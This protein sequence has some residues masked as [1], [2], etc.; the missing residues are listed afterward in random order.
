LTANLL[1]VERPPVH[2]RH[3]EEI[4]MRASMRALSWLA[5][6][7]LLA[8][9]PAVAQ[10]VPK[11]T[12]DPAWPKPLPN[13][14]LLGQVAHVAVDS[15]DHVWLLQRPKSLTDD[16]K[17]ATLK[18]PRNQCCAPAPS[19]M[20]LDADGNFIQGWGFPDTKPWVANEH[21]IWVDRSGSVWIAGNA[22]DDSAIYKF[23]RDGKH[24]L[25]IGVAG[26]TGGSNDT[27]KLGRPATLTV[28]EDA[29]ELIVADG[30]GNRRVIVFDSQ[31]GAFKR[32]WGAYGN[33]PNDDK[34][35]PYSPD[36]PV[37][38]QFA[39]PVHCATPSRDGHLYVCDRTNNRIQVFRKDGT[40]VTEWF[41][42]KATLG[43][44]STWGLAT[45][46]DANQTFLLNND[47]EN[48]IVRI[49]RRSDGQV[50]GSFGRSGRQAGHFHWVHGLAVDSKGNVYTGE[51]DTGKRVQKFKPD[52]PPR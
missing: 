13:N 4:T 11:F 33:K 37:S 30:Y 19:V 5:G 45:W 49:L 8:A 48:N 39:N 26:P 40:Y 34:Q 15:N 7:V 17:G 9:A 32:Y 27:T 43:A 12:V 14:W 16:E 22:N 24:L 23:T 31:T 42:D 10:T 25:T 18:P 28:D 50:V 47:G 20:E 36:A 6:M 41:Y 2:R 35:P 1:A 46:P 44:G 51:V 3:P 38:Q 29:R 21:G 52:A